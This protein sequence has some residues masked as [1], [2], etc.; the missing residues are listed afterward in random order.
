[1]AIYFTVIDNIYETVG[2]A[3]EERRR[4]R[5]LNSTVSSI[6][7]SDRSSVVDQSKF[8]LDTLLDMGVV[9]QARDIDPILKVSTNMHSSSSLSLSKPHCAW[10]LPPPHPCHVR[11]TN[12]CLRPHCHH[13]ALSCHAEHS[14][15]DWS[16]HT[17]L[18]SDRLAVADLLLLPLAPLVS[19][20]RATCRSKPAAPFTPS[21]LLPPPLW[22]TN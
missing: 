4:A 19:L 9:N 3:I 1:M 22:P 8:I 7:M 16:V 6:E 15:N 14:L 12:I 11:V 17:C 5:V 13:R 20:S 10:S 18:A 2:S 21:P